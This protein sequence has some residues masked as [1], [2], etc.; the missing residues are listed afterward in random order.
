M[1]MLLLARDASV[2]ICHSRTRELAAVTIE[3]DLLVAAMGRPRTL[4]VA[5]VMPGAVG[6][7]VGTTPDENGKLV[8]DVDTEAVVGAGRSRRP[9]GVGPMTTAPLLRNTV[10]AAAP[11]HRRL[12]QGRAGAAR[13]F[14]LPRIGRSRAV[15]ESGW[16]V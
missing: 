6:V 2:T 11:R 16:A 9:G 13:A 4:G 12:P 14:Q 1:A 5:H 7:D 10:A 15:G 8:G 3:A